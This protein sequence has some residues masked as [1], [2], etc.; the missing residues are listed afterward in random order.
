MLISCENCNKKFEVSEDLI[1]DQGRL[2]QC[3]SCDYKWFFKN[4]IKDHKSSKT[5]PIFKENKGEISSF[6]ASQD[7]SNIKKQHTIESAEEI[8]ITKQELT[9]PIK[10][11]KQLNYFKIFLVF[12]I[13]IVA[14]IVL[15]DTFKHQI[16]SVFPGTETILFN[17][18]ESLTDIN[19]FI[20]DL[21][22]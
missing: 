8:Q 11:D 9:T 16:S 5:K 13:S 3:G 18:Y 1:P 19:L 7:L 21:I 22:K 15:I 20:R 2:L 12:I 14:L 6:E 4:V 10:K 17:L